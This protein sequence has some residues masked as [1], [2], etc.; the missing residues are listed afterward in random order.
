MADIIDQ[1]QQAENLERAAA[2]S[3]AGMPLGPGPVVIAGRAC[4]RDCEQPINPARLQALPGCSR[5]L[6]CQVEAE[7]Q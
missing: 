2:I 3:R 1:A 7:T 5:C 4:C 6:A